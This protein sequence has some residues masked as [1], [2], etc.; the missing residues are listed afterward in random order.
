MTS[1]NQFSKNIFITGGTGFLGWYLVKQFLKD[2][3]TRLTLLVRARKNISARLRVK[4]LFQENYSLEEYLTL[5]NRITVLEGSITSP[6]L[7]LSKGQLDKL[8]NEVTAI[9]HSAA[10]AE[11]NAPYEKI[12]EINVT[13]TKNVLNFA[14]QCKK[15]TSFDSI[16]HISTIIVSGTYRGTFFEKSL[17]EGQRFRNTYEQTKFEAEI[18]AHQYRNQG[19]NVNIFRPGIIVGDSQTGYAINFRVIYQPIHIFSL[20]IYKQIPAKGSINYNIVPVD[21]LTKA[22]YLI[23]AHNH[24]HNK[25]FHM[26]NS[27]EATGNFIFKTSSEFFGYP[28]P[29]LIPI[30]TFDMSTLTGFRKLLLTPYMPYLNHNGT[31]Y[32]NKGAMRILKECNFKW[33]KIDKKFLHT[34]FQYCLNK[35]FVT[36]KNRLVS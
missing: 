14:S 29:E 17:A 30:D 10:L 13:G 16:N 4:K 36:H 27:H 5:K 35:Q 6:N 23:Y 20:G 8:S 7:G 24:P 28:Q 19:L 12:K 11:F 21:F 32:N 22:I 3:D 31:S 18:L 2:E 33:P 26:T 25:T 1:Q 15:N 9:F 34:I